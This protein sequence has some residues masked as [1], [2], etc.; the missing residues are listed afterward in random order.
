[1]KTSKRKDAGPSALEKQLKQIV[2][3]HP[4][5]R[6]HPHS[7]TGPYVRAVM[8]TAEP[9]LLGQALQESDGSWLVRACHLPTG[10][11]SLVQERPADMT[12]IPAAIDTV[13]AALRRR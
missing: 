12:G 5:V 4:Q 9:V 6:L 8:W 1:M 3:A 11:D 13:L 10:Q 7:P 2:R